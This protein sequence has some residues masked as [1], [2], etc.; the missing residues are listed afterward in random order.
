MDNGRW[1]PSRSRY[2]TLRQNTPRVKST[3]GGCPQESETKRKLQFLQLNGVHPVFTVDVYTG[4]LLHLATV[5]SHFPS[6]FFYTRCVSVGRR[7]TFQAPSL[8]TLSVNLTLAATHCIKTR[9]HRLTTNWNSG[10]RRATC[11][12]TKRSKQWYKRPHKIIS[13][14]YD[15]E[16]DGK[17]NVNA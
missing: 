15:A 4:T 10:G 5:A 9:R 11:R 12:H 16:W 2:F 7:K 14:Y 8:N 1:S 6:G 13:Q 3:G 17:I